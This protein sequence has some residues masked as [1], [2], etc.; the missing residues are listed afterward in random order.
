MQYLNVK[1]KALISAFGTVSAEL[2]AHCNEV[3]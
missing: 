1:W 2:I 3:H